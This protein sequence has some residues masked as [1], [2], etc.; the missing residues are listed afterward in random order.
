[1]SAA[2]R[3]SP[4]TSTTFVISSPAD[5]ILTGGAGVQAAPLNSLRSGNPGARTSATVRQQLNPGAVVERVHFSF[6]YDTGF[7]PTGEGANF[8]VLVAGEQVYGSPRYTDFMYSQ[9]RSNYSAPVAV[10]AASLSIAVPSDSAARVAHL[11]FVF[12]NVSAQVP[13]PCHT[14]PFANSVSLLPCS[15]IVASHVLL[16]Y[17]TPTHPPVRSRS[18]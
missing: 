4:S 5:L 3:A 15:N 9:N 8:S 16:P 14:P 10:D 11:E 17:T 18:E 12:D 1:M 7:G 13:V 6:R 2:P